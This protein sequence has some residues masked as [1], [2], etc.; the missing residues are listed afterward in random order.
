MQPSRYRI[1]SDD[2]RTKINEVIRFLDQQRESAGLGANALT[3]ANAPFFLS[4][5]WNA[6]ASEVWPTFFQS[7]RKALQE[8]G[9]LSRQLRGGDGYVAFVSVFVSLAE[10]LGVS[11]LT[12]E[13]L[14]VNADNS[15]EEGQNGA[16]RKPPVAISTLPVTGLSPNTGRARGS[17]P[18]SCLAVGVP[19]LR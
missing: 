6:Q 17:A 18:L 9:L 1:S 5:C 14:A 19:T 15:R 4:A 10:A 16:E 7:A 11:F 12:L 3:P 13:H 8:D 2:A